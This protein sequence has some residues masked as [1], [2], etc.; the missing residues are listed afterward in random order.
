MKTPEEKARY[1]LNTE[2]PKAKEALKEYMTANSVN[3]SDWETGF[4][5]G[6]LHAKEEALNLPEVTDDDIEKAAN[7]YAFDYKGSVE[8][9]S[10]AFQAGAHWAIKKLKGIL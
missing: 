6:Y 7:E 4:E 9:N 1:L 10:E 2:L 5:S 8:N 3:R